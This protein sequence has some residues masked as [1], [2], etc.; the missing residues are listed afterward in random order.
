MPTIDL[1]YDED[2][3]NS[4]RPD[5]PL[6]ISREEDFYTATAN[7][8]G[9]ETPEDGDDFYAIAP[10]LAFERL[11]RE[12]RVE[13]PDGLSGTRLLPACL[14]VNF[15]ADVID[16]AIELGVL[17]GGDED[18]DDVRVFATYEELLAAF[19][20]VIQENPEEARFLP[21]SGSFDAYEP[22]VAGGVGQWVD[23]MMLDKVTRRTGSLRQYV[24]LAEIFGPRALQVERNDASSQ[25]AMMVGGA[26]RGLLIQTVKKYYYGEDSTAA[27]QFLTGRLQNFLL[28]TR[29]ESPWDVSS[30]DPVYY[31]LD[32]P[33]RAKQIT[34]SRATWPTLVREKIV[35]ALPR[36]SPFDVLLEDVSTQPQVIIRALV[37]IGDA[38]LPGENSQ[39]LA[40]ANIITVRDYVAEH[41]TDY[42]QEQRR[43]GK[44]SA[45]LCKLLLQD[46]TAQGGVAPSTEKEVTPHS[47]DA[48]RD[49]IVAPKPRQIRKAM[50][51]PSFVRL[52]SEYVPSLRDGCLSSEATLEMLGDV[53]TAPTVL[54]KVVLLAS[55]SSRSS[56]YTHLSDFLNL[57]KDKQT[58]M[59]LYLGQSLA[60]DEEEGEVAEHMEQFEYNAREFS[61]LCAGRWSEMD[62]LNH[63]LLALSGEDGG[64]KFATHD[65][66]RLYHFEGMYGHLIKHVSKLWWSIGYPKHI[67]RSRGLTYAGFLRKLQRLVEKSAA[68]EPEPCS[69]LLA[70]VDEF[71]EEGYKR[72]ATNW[73]LTVYGSSPG[74]RE[75]GPWLPASEPLLKKIDD[76]LKEL[77][78]TAQFFQRTQ[79]VFQAKRQASMLPGWE[80]A[81]EGSSQLPKQQKIVDVNDAPE[82]DEARP[83]D[84][85][86]MPKEERVAKNYKSVYYY[87]DGSF[88]KKAWLFHWPGICTKYG[89]DPNELCGCYVMSQNRPQKK[90]LDCQDLHHQVTSPRANSRGNM[91]TRCSP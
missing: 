54:P 71:A 67:D 3:G 27:V 63:V 74:D 15:L 47:E 40:F 32:L 8:M 35:K 79:G 60:F 50:V 45:E 20:A 81:H 52:A 41:Y 49:R 43:A 5:C 33:N 62:H 29:W 68:M 61:L 72:A 22:F 80:Q 56:P 28:D 34:A 25:F 23:A 44:N 21:D 77:K 53:L 12:A 87:E 88:S 1:E 7:V 65:V 42:I 38:V 82:G 57:L 19:D 55:T 46:I 84:V 6:S 30:H 4:A 89:W 64:V 90:A 48:R 58:N 24:E 2:R 76:L 78:K 85:M 31:T 13:D 26:D 17:T 69:R 70:L 10:H 18:G 51:S 36:L 73:D 59:L 14:H 66:K 37:A 9:Y 39:K 75:L 91:L 16:A 11:A 86:G 83:S